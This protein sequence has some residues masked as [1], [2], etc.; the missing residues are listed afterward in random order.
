MRCEFLAGV[1]GLELLISII[2]VAKYVTDLV[3]LR[4]S[5]DNQDAKW[6]GMQRQVGSFV[7]LANET[8]DQV[9]CS[10]NAQSLILRILN[11]RDLLQKG[12]VPDIF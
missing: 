6:F 10:G 8:L 12:L 4:V 9:A 7:R 2:Y 11:F 3:D 1:A 5:S